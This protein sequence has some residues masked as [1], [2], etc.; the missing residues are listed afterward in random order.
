MKLN[1]SEHR[2]PV[3][4][5]DLASILRQATDRQIQFCSW[6]SNLHVD[7]GLAGETDL[8]ILVAPDDADRLDSVLTGNHCVRIAPP[9]GGAHS[10]MTHYLGLDGETRRI[11]HLHVHDRLVL[12][13]RYSKNY[14]LPLVEQFLRSSSA[15]SAVPQPE[16]AME[17]I[18]LSVRALL[19]Y[20]AR[21]A[22][23]DVLKIR[24]P[25]VPETI[26]E[27]IGWCL[28]RTTSDDLS[29]A[30]SVCAGV[31][32]AGIIGAFLHV[33]GTAPRSGLKLWRLKGALESALKAF[34]R[35]SR[36]RSLLT[37]TNGLVRSRLESGHDPRLRVGERGVAVAVLGADGS[38]K[39]TIST[40]LSDWI[41]GKLA[42]SRYYMGSKE[43]SWWTSSSYMI[44][45]IFRRAHRDTARAW[46]DTS[47]AR[48][49]MA[50]MRDTMLAMHHL[51]VARDRLGRLRKIREDV[52]DGRVVIL[53]RY[54]LEVVGST[55][56]LRLLDGPSIETTREGVVGRLADTERSLY[57]RFELPDA[58]LLLEV[59]PAVAIAR[60]PDHDPGTVAA[61]TEGL[62]ELKQLMASID[63]GTSV[64]RID[65]NAPL[66]EAMEQAKEALWT[67]ITTRTE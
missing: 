62:T 40:E 5:S 9:P 47:V 32:P 18:V 30:L 28:E 55:P 22:V 65:A 43:P 51:S 11:F 35:R 54:P 7:A 59:D 63:H 49:A 46:S 13:Q 23:K 67:A 60:K 34:R 38:G 10:G 58:F 31:V 1:S 3:V 37:Y 26:L 19:K 39:T 17:L 16:P 6:K 20:R 8:D 44:F 2:T 27:E 29:R 41:G 42:V 57:R 12:G 33:I 48:R 53:D 52:A 15:D 66:P 64:T 36:A 50:W 24:T 45:R 14:V 25:G 61:K 21:D 56:R 4:L